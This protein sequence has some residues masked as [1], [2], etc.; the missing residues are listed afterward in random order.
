MS[1]FKNKNK[2]QAEKIKFLVP[3]VQRIVNESLQII[4]STEN[5]KTGISRFEII[6]TVLKELI[7]TIPEG[8]V[9]K[10]MTEFHINNQNIKSYDDLKIIDNI[11]NQWLEKIV[12]S[13]IESETRK[14]DIL[15]DKKL[16]KQQMKKALK[17]ALENLDFLPENKMLKTKIADIEKEAKN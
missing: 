7:D 2:E 3:Q 12:F 10:Y 9:E 4:N 16:K 1:W 15:T 17:V 8:E 14:A 5:I 13:Q 6:K 11:K